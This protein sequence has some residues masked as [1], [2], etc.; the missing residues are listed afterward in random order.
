MQYI[1]PMLLH[2][3]LANTWLIFG[4]VTLSIYMYPGTLNNVSCIICILLKEIRKNSIYTI[5][6]NIFFL[7]KPSYSIN[8]CLV[9][10]A[11]YIFI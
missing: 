3:K 4:L 8:L 11:N 2:L 6:L 7:S 1:P 9:I 10:T 5:R